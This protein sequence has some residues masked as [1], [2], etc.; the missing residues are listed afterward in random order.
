[1]RIIQLVFVFLI[2]SGCAT[3]LPRYETQKNSRKENSFGLRVSTNMGEVRAYKFDNKTCS[4]GGAAIVEAA[5]SWGAIPK[6][7][8]GPLNQN[9]IGLPSLSKGA[10]RLF[11]E[12][13][14]SAQ[15]EIYVAVAASSL[16][17]KTGTSCMGYVGFSP[18]SGR[19]YEIGV[20]QVGSK[21]VINIL[22]ISVDDSGV[23]KGLRVPQLHVEKND[24]PAAFDHASGGFKQSGR[25]F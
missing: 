7:T 14:M 25:V 9:G 16:M 5:R 24:C 20:D 12:L 18:L 17:Y 4:V 10:D 21:C 8:G 2:V 3:E 6:A 19:V 1:M 15:K 11:G 13:A 23:V 22:E